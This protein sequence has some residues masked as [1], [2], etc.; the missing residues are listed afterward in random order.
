MLP[1]L[2][3]TDLDG[4][5]LDPRGTYDHARLDRTLRALTRHGSRLVVATGDPLNHVQALFGG[6]QE[7]AQ[8]TYV[9]EDGALTATGRGTI[10]QTRPIPAELVRTA[11]AWMQTAPSFTGNFLIS[12]G[13]T[14]AYTELPA[15]GDR[16]RA[17]QAFYPSLT[18]VAQLGRVTVPILK[19]DVTWHHSDVAPQVAA[20]NREFAG[21]LV[22][23]SSGLGGLNV[24]LP[25][26]NKAT[27]VQ[28][29]A[30]DWRVSR[31]QVAAFGD[32]GNDLALLRWA[33]QGIAVANAAPEVRAIAD[34]QTT[35][36]N[37]APVVLDQIDA[38]LA[39]FEE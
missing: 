34:Q 11:V 24:S 19:L 5:F 33:G 20:F 39:T 21:R 4:T 7:A 2:I 9:V 23:T 31:E 26:V 37:A 29:L 28:A 18:H 13:V 10:C 27:A 16:F 6:L 38:W 17:S 25:G 15:T 12:C 14:R 3:A 36:T 22:A 30:Q 35:R 32:S 1:R 8:L